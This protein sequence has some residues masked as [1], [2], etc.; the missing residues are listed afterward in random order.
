[1]L[2]FHWLHYSKATPPTRRVEPLERVSSF[3]RFFPCAA[4]AGGHQF[5]TAPMIEYAI[6]IVMVIFAAAFAWLWFIEQK[7]RRKRK[8]ALR[9]KRSSDSAQSTSPATGVPPPFAGPYS[10]LV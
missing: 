5:R 8:E 1:M 6:L 4:L 7:K 3:G 2:E 10:A 9:Q